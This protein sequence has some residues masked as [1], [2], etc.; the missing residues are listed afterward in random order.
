MQMMIMMQQMMKDE[1]ELIRA[2][3]KDRQEKEELERQQ[4]RLDEKERRER[5]EQDRQQRK[6]EENEKREKE[7]QERQLTRSMENERWKEEMELKRKKLDEQ[8]RIED[9]KARQIQR[10]EEEAVEREENRKLAE[11]EKEASKKADQ[12]KK[13]ERLYQASKKID[14]LLMRMPADGMEVPMFFRTVENYF[15]EF[16][17]DE[18]L[19]VALLLP[20][21]NEKA[22]RVVIR[23]SEEQRSKYEEVKKQVLREFKLTPRVYRANFLDA[24]KG[25]SES[26]TQ[27][28]S[29]LDILFGYYTEGRNVNNFNDLKNHIIAD[30]MKDVMQLKLK[31]F[32]IGKEGL[33]WLPPGRLADAADTYVTNV[34]EGGNI[35]ST[36]GRDS[37]Y[38][39]GNA[40]GGVRRITTVGDIHQHCRE[41]GDHSRVD[42]SS[43]DHKS[44][45]HSSTDHD[46][47][48]KD[49]I[50]LTTAGMT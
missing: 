43:T 26:W 50:V 40:Y 36:G 25:T 6:I 19:K 18:D 33:E 48:G 34:M 41:T 4:L 13:S 1:R 32:I 9:L 42:H 37:G 10:D 45:G 15:N 22:T 12:Q 16:R 7:E 39:S 49:Q 30:K 46:S 24:I 28:A 21:L 17:I 38:N 5:E 3:E 47:R 27:F 14:K 31:E 29:R 44:I 20:H 35:Q 11:L 8:I 2:R 23:L